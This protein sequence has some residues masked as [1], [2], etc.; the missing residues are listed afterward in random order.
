MTPSQEKKLNDIHVAIIGNKETGIRG[1]A[2][3]VKNLEDY[4]KKDQA[5]KNKLIGGISVGTP[6]FIGII[7][8]AKSK[9]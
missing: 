3:R 8:W 6:L 4:K 5:L 1:L 7:E 9:L 2:E